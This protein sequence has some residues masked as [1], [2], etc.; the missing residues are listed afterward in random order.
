[1]PAFAFQRFN[2]NVASS[3][4]NAAQVIELAA[5]SRPSALEAS[6]PVFWLLSGAV[7]CQA[8]MRI[9]PASEEANKNVE[10]LLIV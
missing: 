4:R 5:A 3:R 9:D 2:S 8:Y 7:L 6:V 1:M 10:Q